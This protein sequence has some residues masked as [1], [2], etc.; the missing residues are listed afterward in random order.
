MGALVV[1]LTELP[2]GGTATARA[3][4]AD[5]QRGGGADRSPATGRRR[6]LGA[7]G[8]RRQRCPR[9]AAGQGRLHRRPPGA[10][11]GS[12]RH[13][14]G[15]ERPL[16]PAGRR[17]TRNSLD[18]LV[19]RTFAPLLDYDARHRANLYETLRTLF[20]HRL[21]V[22]ETADALHIHRNTLQKRL[23]HVEQLLAIDLER[24][25]RHRRHS[26]GPARRRAPRRAASLGRATVAAAACARPSPRRCA[27][28][29]SRRA[30]VV[31]GRLDSRPLRPHS[32]VARLFA[33]REGVAHDRPRRRLHSTEEDAMANVLMIHPDK[34][35]GC[36]NCELACSFEHEGQFRPAASRVQAYTWE[37][38]GMSVPM[39]CQQ[40]DDA[41]CVKV[42]PTGAMHRSTALANLVD[43][44]ESHLH[45]LQ[46]VHRRLPLR[47]CALRR[48]LQQHLQVRHLPGRTGVR[49]LL[50][51]RRPRVRRATSSRCARARRPTPP[52]SRKPFRR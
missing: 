19:Q 29:H 17:S 42:C 50:P 6:L 31:A 24:P 10:A 45:P 47:Q 2:D 41:A 21:A 12:R 26:P 28:D 34:C 39:M 44:D 49:G 16:P 33:G 1:V 20:E 51:Q 9:P 36:R 8:R 7:A 11:P 15:A 5:L 32:S 27:R 38:E 30:R 40:C 52:S 18:D 3:L 25:R 14:R 4:L 48:R 46:D 35:T 22:Q 13:L 43:W 23:A 37:R